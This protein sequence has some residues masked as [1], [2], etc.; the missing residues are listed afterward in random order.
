[1]TVRLFAIHFSYQS[2]QLR[3][4]A[5]FKRVAPP[6]KPFLANRANLINR[7]L[8][9]AASANALNAASPARMKFGSQR[10]DNDGFEMLVHFIQADDDYRP[11]LCDFAA[12]CGIKIREV[13]AVAFNAPAY[14]LSP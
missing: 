7:N 5:R 12:A 10:A 8:G 2:A 9:L 6:A 14:H 3:G 4:S 13:D 11:C 1:M